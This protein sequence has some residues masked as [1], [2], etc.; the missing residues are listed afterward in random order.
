M[1]NFTLKEWHIVMIFFTLILSIIKNDLISALKT[2]ILI[3]EQR[4]LRGKTVLILSSTGNWH[5]VQIQSYQYEIPFIRSGGVFI[6]HS[7]EQ[8]NH[9]QEKISFNNWQLQRVRF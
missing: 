8:G 2:A 9:I 7:D 4:G 3:N 1:E 5:K 6:A